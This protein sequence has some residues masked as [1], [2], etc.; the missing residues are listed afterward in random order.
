VKYRSLAPLA[1]LL[2]CILCL[3]AQAMVVG[4][5]GVTYAIKEKDM[6]EVI[7]NRLS[8]VDLQKLQE[9]IRISLA[10]A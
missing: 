8:E 3:Q 10:S 2:V 4:R 9:D 1:L 6:L 7:H 5:E